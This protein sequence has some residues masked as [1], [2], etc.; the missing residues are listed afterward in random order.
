MSSDIVDQETEADADSA[1]FEHLQQA[2][3]INRVIHEPARLL[4]LAVL[5]KIDW[6]DFN[7]LLT[8]TRLSKGNLSKQSAKLEEAGY[9]EIE[10]GYKG[11]IPVT[12]YRITTEGKRE[13]QR[14]WNQMS[15]L[16]HEINPGG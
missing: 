12:R 7:F 9:I 4:L 14:Y 11:K 2:L 6:A 8:A 3:E 1:E 15:I 13:L 5:S 16:G 10:K